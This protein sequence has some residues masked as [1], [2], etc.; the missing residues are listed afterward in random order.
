MGTKTKIIIASLLATAAFLFWLSEPE[1]EEVDTSFNGVYKFPDGQLATIVPSTA[2]RF[3]LRYENGNVQSLNHSGTTVFQVANGFSGKESIATGEFL[4][5]QNG[6]TNGI[7][8][9]ESGNSL[10]IERLPLQEEE[11]YFKS[12]ELTLRGKLTMPVGEGPFPVVIMI[13]GSE[14]YS[15][16]DYYP[17]PYLLAAHGIAGFKFDKRGTGLSEGEYTQHFPTLADDV[18]A[19]TNILKTKQQ[20]NSAQI[21]LAGFSQGGWIAPLVAQKIDIQSIMIGYGC[22]ISVPREDRWGYVY[23]LLDQ[24]FGE[25]EIAIADEMNKQLD[26]ILINADDAAWDR[27]FSLRDQHID[28]PWFRAIAGSDSLLGIVAEKS[29]GSGAGLTPNFVWKLYFDWK[30]GDGPG[31]NRSYEPLDTLSKI[32]TPSLWLLA[33]EDS[34]VPTNETT[35]VLQDLKRMGKNIE[36]IVYPD[37]EHGNVLFNK[38]ET[39]QRVYTAYASSYYSDI[40]GWF[41][42]KNGL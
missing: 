26:A 27:L 21:N 20:I 12:G 37:A 42:S 18:V 30:R 9:S 4:Q 28:K 10:S 40:V 19:A 22:A 35:V 6:T 16:V 36:F 24:G 1:T 41:K 8:W 34:S 17:L 38:D 29:L 2:T 11:I 3:R 33:G 7:S 25:Q 15:A 13:H 5:S 39:G 14:A 23:Q 31:F 32:N